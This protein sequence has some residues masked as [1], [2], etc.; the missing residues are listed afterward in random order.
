MTFSQQCTLSDLCITAKSLFC[1]W[2]LFPKGVNI[3]L[4]NRC[5][6]GGKQN[7]NKL[8]CKLSKQGNAL[9]I[10][11]CLQMKSCFKALQDKRESMQFQNDTYFQYVNV[12]GKSVLLLFT[13][14]IHP[15]RLSLGLTVHSF[16][17]TC[18]PFCFGSK[19]QLSGVIHLA[20]PLQTC[21]SSEIFHSKPSLYKHVFSQFTTN[22]VRMMSL[23]SI[24]LQNPRES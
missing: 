13:H 18:K 16:V 14:S 3:L 21:Y 19:P 20:P 2:F 10:T 1:S 8:K 4:A 7:L 17:V 12:S 24:P 23:C 15:L 9:Y 11:R 5:L 6:L 22:N